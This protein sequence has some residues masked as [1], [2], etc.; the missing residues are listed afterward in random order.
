MDDNDRPELVSNSIRIS[1]WNP[2]DP[3]EKKN[4]IQEF[5]KPQSKGFYHQY[6]QAYMDCHYASHQ[7]AVD[8]KRKL[9]E[10]PIAGI[11]IHVEFILGE[12][13][14]KDKALK[15]KLRQFIDQMSVAERNQLMCDM[16]Y[17]VLE[18]PSDAERLL[19]MYPQLEF[20]VRVLTRK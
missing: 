1:G 15:D 8:M 18:H 9:E 12:K 19:L 3:T 7:D 5:V 11:Q 10:H 14:K 2:N 6:E 17:M 16:R 20:A 13:M 4:I